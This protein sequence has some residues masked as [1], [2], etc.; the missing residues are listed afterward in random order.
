MSSTRFKRGKGCVIASTAKIARGA[1]L[2]ERVR[3]AD[4]AI[5][6]DNVTIG[7]DCFIG[8]HVILGEPTRD[9]YHDPKAYRPKPTTI[10]ARSVIR[11]F[12]C[13]YAGVRIGEEFECGPSISIRENAAIGVRCKI[14][15]ASDIQGE[16]TIGDGC[17]F[18][19]SVH[20][21]QFTKI[22]N[23]VWLFPFVLML[24][25]PAA[26]TARGVKLRGPTVGDY[27]VVM[28]RSLLMPGVTLGQHVVVAANSKVTRDFADWT[29][30]AGD[31][32]KKVC[33]SRK[34]FHLTD[35]EVRRPYPWMLHWREGT[36]WERKIP[37][38]WQRG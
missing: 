2:G 22:G 12:A 15:N 10:G 1:V 30:I 25:D 13:I 20:I 27:S 26:P 35:G 9:F 36:P 17:R 33:D 4:W 28:A 7:N 14:G 24:N 23:Y 6:G 5:I 31:P 3:V 19:S 21:P 32:A 29:M 38:E 16:C 37:I 11:A 34:F 8:P 18:H